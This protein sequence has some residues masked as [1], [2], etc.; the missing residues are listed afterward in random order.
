MNSFL[1]IYWK[2]HE[3]NSSTWRGK[4]RYLLTQLYI[5]TLVPKHQTF[6]LPAQEKAVMKYQLLH[7]L[8]PPNLSPVWS[9]LHTARKDEAMK[10]K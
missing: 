3:P 4:K 2:I 1:V 6:P 8:S 9:M 7:K 10:L 5:G